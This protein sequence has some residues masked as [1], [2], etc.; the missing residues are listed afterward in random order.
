M[1]VKRHV[2]QA[3]SNV[4][5]GALCQQSASEGTMNNWYVSAS[6]VTQFACNLFLSTGLTANV[7]LVLS[8]IHMLPTPGCNSNIIGNNQMILLLLLLLLLLTKLL[9]SMC[10]DCRSIAAK[11]RN[12]CQRPCTPGS[13]IYTF[14]QS[15]LFADVCLV[16]WGQGLH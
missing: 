13:Y 8:S 15:H 7:G 9:F 5:H 11:R 4:L 16:D 12:Y 1:V 10:L 14:W 6:F 3:N 2:I